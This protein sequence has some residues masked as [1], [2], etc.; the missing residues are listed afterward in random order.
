MSQ[1]HV[2]T[3]ELSEFMPFED[4]AKSKLEGEDLE[5]FIAGQQ[6]PDV[7]DDYHAKYAHVYYDWMIEYKIT[8]VISENGQVIK[9]NKYTDL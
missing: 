5:Y 7:D 8:H 1:E 4:Y 6:D 2:F 9:N 3:S